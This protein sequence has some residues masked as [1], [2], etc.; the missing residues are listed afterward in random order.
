[1]S[2]DTVGGAA[3]SKKPLVLALAAVGVVFVIL[4]ILFF[5]GVNLGPLDTIGHSG[6]VN[7]GSHGIRGGISAVVAVLALGGAWFMNKKSSN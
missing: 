5:A 1:M 3:G 6:K 7:T 4:A 2:S